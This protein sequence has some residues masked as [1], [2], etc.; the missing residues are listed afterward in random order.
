MADYNIYIHAI[1]TGNQTAFNPTVPWSQRQESESIAP[2]QSS[3][4]GLSSMGTL[5]AISRVGA[6]MSNPN[7]IV[8]SAFS[9]V[10]KAIPYVAAAYVVVNTLVKGYETA[11]DFAAIESGDYGIKMEWENQRRILHAITDPIG[12]QIQYVKTK[13]QLKIDNERHRLN[14]E[15]LGDS[16]LN[17]YT[18][19]GI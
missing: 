10:A 14:R 7:S 18:N 3:G 6:F 11:M 9:K 15:L 12:T 17:S 8:S 16:V 13:M 4:G 5:G 19:R 1:G 2:T